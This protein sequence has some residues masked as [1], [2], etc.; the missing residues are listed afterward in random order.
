MGGTQILQIKNDPS[1]QA[2]ENIIARE[3]H[4]RL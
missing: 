4:I 3:I 2:K 1:N